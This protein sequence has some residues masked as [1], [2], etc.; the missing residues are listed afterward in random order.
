MP[1]LKASPGSCSN[2][3]PASAGLSP[4]LLHSRVVLLSLLL[5]LPAE[6]HC[7]P[8]ATRTQAF[9]TEQGTGNGNGC[10]CSFG[11]MLFPAL[12]WKISTYTNP[13]GWHCVLPWIC[14]VL[15][16]LARPSCASR[17]GCH[18]CQAGHRSGNGLVAHQQ[19]ALCSTA[20]QGQQSAFCRAL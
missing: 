9:S 15:P 16:P 11:V 3:G 8:A 4:S 14:W 10:K 12:R 13:T 5:L 1:F 7:S 18:P 17:A 19:P 6:C 20:L 2:S